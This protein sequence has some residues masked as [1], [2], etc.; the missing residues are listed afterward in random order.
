MNLLR[1]R[2]RRS[3]QFF[4][5]DSGVLVTKDEHRPDFP[6]QPFP[7]KE[8]LRVLL[9]LLLLTGGMLE[10][11]RAAYARMA[12]SDP[13]QFYKAG[14]LAIEKSR[15]VMATWLVAAYCLW[16]AKFRPHQLIL[17]QSK[18][19]DDAANVVYDKDPDTARMSFMEAHLPSVLQD[20]IFPR[21][22]S[23]CNLRYPT[24]SRIWGI[25]EGADIIRSNT[26]SVLVSDEAAFQPEFASARDA[27]MPAI[28]GGGQ[29]VALSSAAPGAFAQ[30]VGAEGA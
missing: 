10:P 23:R 16:R 11:E 9:D 3:A 17:W 28:K 22:A 26:P 18:K 25:P 5:F 8:Y 30:W 1:E 12:G 6:V 19:E 4:I 2:C 24:G 13:E 20:N 14:M 15:Q 29:L 21:G 27:A 7:N